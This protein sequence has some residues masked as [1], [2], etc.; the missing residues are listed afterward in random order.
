MEDSTQVTEEKHIFSNQ[1]SS[2]QSISSHL[3]LL[4]FSEEAGM[5]FDTPEKEDRYFDVKYECFEEADK[6]FV[7]VNKCSETEVSY[8]EEFSSEFLAFG[9]FLLDFWSQ[10]KT[11]QVLIQELKH[12]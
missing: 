7:T 6:C 5:Y 9:I 2:I 3:F 10:L 4:A 1:I 11:Y 8:F 12:L